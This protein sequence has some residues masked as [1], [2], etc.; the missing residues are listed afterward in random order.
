MRMGVIAVLMHRDDVVEMPGV[1]LEEP[2]GHIRRDVAHILPTRAHG[3]GHEHVGG[4]SEL[5]LEARIHRLAKRSVRSL[6]SPASSFVLPSRNPLE[7][8]IWV[9]L[10]VR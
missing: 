6:M 1:G 10:V 4:L 9:D 8:T 3:E 2:L 7:S 5:G